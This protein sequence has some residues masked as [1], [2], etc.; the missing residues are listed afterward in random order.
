MMAQWIALKILVKKVYLWVKAYWYVP[1][2]IAYAIVTWFFF[3]QK[4][5]FMLD[6]L[7]DTR[8]AHKKEIDILNKSKEEEV[9]MIK[10]KVGEHL[11]RAEEAEKRF[12]TRSAD[13]SK[14]T[15]TRAEELKNM[16]NKVL[17]TELKKI[18]KRRKK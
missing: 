9:G 13:I 8:K 16:D 1:F 12:N 2:A 6:N 15:D 10:S 11:E 5:A 17:A 14:R 4:A 7:R 3:R 18:I